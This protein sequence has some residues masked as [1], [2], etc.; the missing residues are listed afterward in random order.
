MGLHR[1]AQAEYLRVPRGD[2]ACLK[3]PG[4]PGDEYE[5][6]FLM[7]ADI[8]P[9]AYFGNELAMTGPGK[10]V[11]VFGAGPVGLLSVHSAM[12]RGA[13]LIYCVDKDPKR[14]EMAKSMGAMPIN[15]LD[16]D[17]VLQIAEHLKT[18]RPLNDAQRPGEEKILRGVDCVIDAVG[19]QAYD[20]ANPD[21]YKANQVLID[22]ARIANFG[23]ALGIIGVYLRIDPSAPNDPG[24]LGMMS[25]PWGMMWEKGLQIGTGQTPVKRFH[26]FLRD[27]VIAGRAK[28]GVIVTDHIHIRD[29]PEAYKQ[30]DKRAGMVK[31]VIRFT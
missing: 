31:P 30:F 6:D 16:G 26:T 22:C 15:F 19:Y 9:T 17:P 29:A 2:W 4:T 28:P 11:A 27:Q 21:R 14:L 13:A 1:G 8:F 25:L 23:G 20:R 10:T 18:I 7:L 3:L 5:D 12:I 24:S